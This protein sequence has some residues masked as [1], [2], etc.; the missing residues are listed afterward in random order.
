MA[1]RLLRGQWE[2]DG[3][4]RNHHGLSIQSQL[5]KGGNRWAKETTRERRKFILFPFIFILFI[6]YVIQFIAS[7]DLHVPVHVNSG[8]SVVVDIILVFSWKFET[9]FS[10]LL[11]RTSKCGLFAYLLDKQI[12][13]GKYMTWNAG[14]YRFT[15]PIHEKV[16]LALNYTVSF[17]YFYT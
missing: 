2:K 9:N 5:C 6:S 4:R 11:S 1:W 12:F 8:T 16:S 14:G 15:P 13:R 3:R 17:Y 10:A 7:C